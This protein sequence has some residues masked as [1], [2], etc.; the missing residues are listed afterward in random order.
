VVTEMF[1]LATATVAETKAKAA[2]KIALFIC[3]TLCLSFRLQSY[4]NF[5]VIVAI[6]RT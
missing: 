6:S 5:E 2:V 3:V 4:G 1:V